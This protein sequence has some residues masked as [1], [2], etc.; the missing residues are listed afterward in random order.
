MGAYH[1]LGHHSE[2]MVLE[3]YLAAYRGVILSPVNYG[4]DETAQQCA[5]FRRD[6]QALD[7]VFDPQLY[8]P[9]SARGHLPEWRYMPGDFETADL[10]SVEW[11]RGVLEGVVAA[12]IPFNPDAIC[13]P[14]M[15]PQRGFVNGHYT[16][17]VNVANALE[18][19]T[20]GEQIRPVA[21]A[22]VGLED[23]GRERRYLE[24]ASIL[25]RY[26]GP[27]IYLVLSDD[28]LPRRE[29]TDSASIEAALRLIKLLVEAGYIAT[30]AFTSTEMILWKAVGAQNVA[31]GKFFNLRRFASSRF[32]DE[33][34]GGGRN[35]PYWFEP[36]LL[37]FLREAD[38]RRFRREWPLSPHHEGNPFSRQILGNLDQQ[39]RRAWLADSWR[40]YL[41][42][43]AETDRMYGESA[44]ENLV[45]TNQLI[46]TAAE[47]WRQVRED[48]L[49]FE[50]EIN[51]GSWIRSWDIA[52]GELDRKR[53]A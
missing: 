38:L 34:E 7:L 40:Q 4:P 12:C 1:Q 53:G 24:V 46:A 32:E 44:A 11:W 45:V 51:D 20:T 48:G 3:Q 13:S 41:F 33:A 47:T 15:F 35:L 9:S 2:S 23:L 36:S 49:R 29:R 31:T 21:T 5:R 10:S 28:T 25:T 8:V 39:E 16:L 37:A 18:E 43:F 42:W 26:R 6:N 17:C 27:E 52:L 19:L 50:E 22:V 30:V 14:A